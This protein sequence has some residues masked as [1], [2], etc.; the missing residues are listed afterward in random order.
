MYPAANPGLLHT[1]GA[2]SVDGKPAA[3][4]PGPGDRPALEE[5]WSTR[6]VFVAGRQDGWPGSARGRERERAITAGCT[7][8]CGVGQARGGAVAHRGQFHDR[9]EGR[10]GPQRATPCER[11]DALAPRNACRICTH[12]IP[13]LPPNDR[14]TRRSTN[15]K[16]GQVGER[17]ETGVSVC[18]FF[19]PALLSGFSGQC[20]PG[21]VCDQSR[22][23]ERPARN[24]PNISILYEI[25]IDMILRIYR[26]Y[27]WMSRHFMHKNTPLWPVSRVFCATP[28]PA[29]PGPRT[30]EREIF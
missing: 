4:R 10:R 6:C 15:V 25:N 20:R 7:G 8:G 16:Q 24:V 3:S 23:P 29:S 18:L 26:I 17:C 12:G 30:L 13:L 2:R 5:A 27:H 22:A 14:T 9:H 11:V 19:L 28:G 1:R 21:G